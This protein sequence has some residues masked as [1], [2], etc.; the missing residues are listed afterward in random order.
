[1]S[2]G[3]EIKLVIS[4]QIPKGNYVKGGVRFEGSATTGTLLGDFAGKSQTALMNMFPF[5]E[6]A[7]EDRPSYTQAG[8]LL[9]VDDAFMF[10]PNCW[11]YDKS[12]A[13]GTEEHWVA[14]YKVDQSW[15]K[16]YPGDFTR[17]G[18][19]KYLANSSNSYL[20]SV[21]GVIPTVNMNQVTAMGQMPYYK[22]GANYRRAVYMDGRVW[23]QYQVLCMIYMNCRNFQKIYQGM[24][25]S[26]SVGTIS[27][28][29]TDERSRYTGVTEE[30]G[31]VGRLGHGV[32]TGEITGTSTTSSLD[33]SKR[34]FQILG[35]ENPYGF[36]WTNM[37][38]MM[39]NSGHLLIYK[40]TDPLLPANLN[41][42]G[43]TAY[44]DVGDV[45][46]QNEGWQVQVC[47]V[48]GYGY[49]AKSG[50]NSS[51][52]NGDYY[53]YAIDYKLSFVGGCWHNGAQGGLL[54]LRG[55][56]GFGDAWPD[57][58]FRLSLEL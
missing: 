33:A 18:I 43:S 36:L 17:L 35:I 48:D 3:N 16:S 38:G 55:G 41:P 12:F 22:R 2:Y 15:H 10:M 49:V 27:G 28:D 54:A 44:V 47:D 25:Y 8:V 29:I 5:S 58:G 50:G 20:H 6:M 1:M 4:D 19:S 7:V 34:P 45:L 31:S 32:V 42:N 53:W 9:N 56:D 37:Y 13:D 30:S 14:N 46:L 11:R 51:I 39:H 23:R 52:Y 57:D 24:Q 26:Y 40:G 21:S